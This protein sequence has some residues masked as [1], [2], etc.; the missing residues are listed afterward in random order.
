VRRSS[1]FALGVAVFVVALGAVAVATW[2][3][4]EDLRLTAKSAVA[5]TLTGLLVFARSLHR[6]SRRVAGQSCTECK[7]TV[8]R[9]HEGEFCAR[10]D[11][12]L[13]ARC[14]SGHSAS[15]HGAAP[16]R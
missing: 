10:C 2:L 11:A 4:T 5:V 13:H 12:P 14:V 15:A 8:V 9:E 6:P 3:A 16:F 7:R 1:Q